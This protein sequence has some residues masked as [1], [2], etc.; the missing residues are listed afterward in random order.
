M[1]GARGGPADIGEV[2]WI[3]W[4]FVSGRMLVFGGL[5]IGPWFAPRRGRPQALVVPI[6]IALVYVAT[7]VAAFAFQHNPLWLPFLVEG[8]S[9]LVATPGLQATM[10]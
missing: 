2:I 3:V 1:H 8:A 10:P 7:G 6:V 5:I 9:L 4:Y